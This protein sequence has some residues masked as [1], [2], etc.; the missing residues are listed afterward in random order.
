M[1]KRYGEVR[2]KITSAVLAKINMVALVLSF[3]NA[4]MAQKIPTKPEKR[5]APRNW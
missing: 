3:V 1:E 5:K 2:I 4:K